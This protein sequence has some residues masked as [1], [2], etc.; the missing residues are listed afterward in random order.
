MEETGGSKTSGT[1]GV[2]LAFL[3]AAVTPDRILAASH[4][5][6]ARGG[7]AVALRDHRAVGREA[8]SGETRENRADSSDPNRLREM[9]CSAGAEFAG[10]H[11]TWLPSC[12]ATS[13][14]DGIC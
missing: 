8:P 6:A 10:A 2:V 4:G 3:P 1:R 12:P 14:G 7:K 5:T 9:T 13:P 11:Q